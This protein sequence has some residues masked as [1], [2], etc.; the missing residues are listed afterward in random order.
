MTIESQNFSWSPDEGLK[1]YP[2][3]STLTPSLLIV[4][5]SA[6]LA[7]V[8]A[9]PLLSLSEHYPGATIVGCSSA[10]GILGD[11]VYD[12]SLVGSAIQ[13]EHTRHKVVSS[14]LTDCDVTEAAQALAEGLAAPDLKHLFVLSDGVGVNGSEIAAALHEQLGNGVVITGGLA[15]DEARFQKTFTFHNQTLQEGGLVVVGLYGESIRVGHG[16]M[17]GWDPFGPTRRVTRSEGNQLFELDNSSAL[18]LYRKYLGPYAEGLPASGL[19]FPLSVRASDDAPELVRTLLA[20]DDKSG[21]MIFAGD[22]PEG[23]RARLMRANF[24]R[25]VD[26]SQNA[27]SMSVTGMTGLRPQLALLIS[28]VGRKLVL[29]DR[30]GEEVEVVRDVVGDEAAL[31]GFYSYGELCP[32]SSG[33]CELHNQTMTITTLAEA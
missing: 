2:A 13:F 1:K 20:I 28:C 16:S 18:E 11:H 26:G 32:V 21:S 9:E 19:K 5:V 24:D 6:D 17:G 12:G 31:L 15:G 14:P 30:I 10:G 25:L 7:S 33:H 29:G 27:A 4:F 23:S 22:I 3:S 8:W